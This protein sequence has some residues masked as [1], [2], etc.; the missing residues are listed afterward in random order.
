[1]ALNTLE[2]KTRQEVLDL[3]LELAFNINGDVLQTA[4]MCLNNREAVFLKRLAA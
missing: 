1:M 2:D 4:R 3:F